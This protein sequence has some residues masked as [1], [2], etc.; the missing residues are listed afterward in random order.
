MSILINIATIATG[1]ILIALIVY[2]MVDKKM[3]E[4]QSVLW[5]LIGL[6]TIIIG[7]YPRIINIVAEKLGVWYAPAVSFLI[8]YIGLLFIVLRTT[9]ITSIQGNQINELFM[10]VI[11]LKDEN[12]KLKKEL[13]SIKTGADDY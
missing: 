6:V 8:A 4:S 10:D 12:K 7:I 5:I 13:K 3:S 11:L 1:V 2:L 9:V